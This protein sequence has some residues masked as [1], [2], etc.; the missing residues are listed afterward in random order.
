M[1]KIIPIFLLIMLTTSFL[2]GGGF[3]INEHGARGMSLAGAFT[4]IANDPSAIYYNPA[5]LYQIS[6]T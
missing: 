4:A 1:K 6:G 5:G 3:Q 2:Y